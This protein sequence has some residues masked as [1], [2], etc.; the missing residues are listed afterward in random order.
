MAENRC[1]KASLGLALNFVVILKVLT[2]RA[3]A[4]K[5]VGFVGSLNVV[6]MGFISNFSGL[7]SGGGCLAILLSV[8]KCLVSMQVDFE[9]R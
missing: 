8:G 7:D 2:P 5:C 1:F 9:M 4:G 3:S 6:R